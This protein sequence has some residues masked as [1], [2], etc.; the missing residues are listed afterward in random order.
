VKPIR[1]FAIDRLIERNPP[2]FVPTAHQIKSPEVI[3]R[4]HGLGSRAVDQSDHADWMVRQGVVRS[5]DDSF[6]GIATT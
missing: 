6:Y 5:Q 4:R 1:I 3:R 2:V